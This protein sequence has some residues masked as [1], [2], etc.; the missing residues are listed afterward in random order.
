MI[1]LFDYYVRNKIPVSIRLKND[2]SQMPLGPVVLT[3][4]AAECGDDFVDYN[5]GSGV[6]Q[7]VVTAMTGDGR[8]NQKTIKMP[9]IF[10]A[11]SVLWVSTGPVED[12][13]PLI[14]T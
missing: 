9:L 5:A 7:A 10:D 6:Y 13:P 1:R 8:G 4:A 11:D 2:N 12:T 3:F 14:V